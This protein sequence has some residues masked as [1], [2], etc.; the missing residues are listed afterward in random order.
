MPQ[1]KTDTDR[2]QLGSGLDRLEDS[3][4]LRNDRRD[5]VITF[6]R[7]VVGKE[8]DVRGSSG[9]WLEGKVSVVFSL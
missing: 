2:S 3:D 8:Y 6:D 7:I 1:W 5:T 4:P 9:I